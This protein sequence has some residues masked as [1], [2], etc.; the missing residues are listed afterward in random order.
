MQIKSRRQARIAEALQHLARS[1][2]PVD[3][4]LLTRRALMIP[5]RFARHQPHGPRPLL[6]GQPLG[7]FGRF[8]LRRPPG[9]HLDLQLQRHQSLSNVN[10]RQ[11][12]SRLH[13]QHLHAALRHIHQGI[14]NDRPANT[15]RHDDPD[16][17]SDPPS[18]AALARAWLP[19]SGWFASH[20]RSGFAIPVVI[21]RQ[22][23]QIA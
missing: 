15:F 5:L 3:R 20:S 9:R 11:I 7:P 22:P 4:R 1:P 8:R 19:A 16:H 13:L 2:H 10:T 14:H 17:S 21:F 6:V 12:T 23:L 18:V